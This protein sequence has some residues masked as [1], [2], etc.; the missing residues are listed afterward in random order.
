MVPYFFFLKTQVNPPPL[1]PNFFFLSVLF[2]SLNSQGISIEADFVSFTNHYLRRTIHP[3]NEKCAL[4]FDFFFP[5]AS[6]TG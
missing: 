1:P 3:S 4:S 2:S 5:P 6:R